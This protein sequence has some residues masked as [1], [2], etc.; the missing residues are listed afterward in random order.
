L[1]DGS[2]RRFQFSCGL[3]FLHE[4]TGCVNGDRQT[5]FCEE[6]LKTL[7]IDCAGNGKKWLDRVKDHVMNPIAFHPSNPH[8]L[9]NTDLHFNLIFVSLHLMKNVL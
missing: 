5:N 6:T 8:A 9:N 1:S 2:I 7:P 3:H 4:C